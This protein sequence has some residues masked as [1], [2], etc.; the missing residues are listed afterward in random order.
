MWTDLFLTAVG[1]LTV[2]LSVL[3]AATILIGRP[4]APRADRFLA[5]FLLVSAV[6][7]AGW[8]APLMPAATSQWLVFRL[9][10]AY[11][12]MP[13]LLAYVATLGAAKS[14][15]RFH[16]WAGSVLV[17]ASIF[18]LTPRALGMAGTG[19]LPQLVSS[20]ADLQWNDVA[21]HLQ[22][23]VY[24]VLI[25]LAVFS[26]TSR[27]TDPETRRWLKVLLVVS[28]SAHTLV[29]AKS[30]AWM[31]GA[32]QLFAVLNV[33][34]GVSAASVL[35]TLLLLVLLKGG[36]AATT[37]TA[38]QPRPVGAADLAAMARIHDVMVRTLP[39]LDPQL[40]LRGLARR[41][42][43]TSRE[44][45]RLINDC[46]GIHFFDFVN[47]YRTQTAAAY[48][49]DP[50]RAERSVLEIAYEVGFNSKS[51]FNT[52]FR[53]HRGVTPSSVRQARAIA[54]DDHPASDFA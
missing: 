20:G 9:P 12:Q 10:V 11:L 3:L 39:Y 25:A 8:T 4:G 46:E 18:S 23:Y 41:V 32:T 50:V 30:A 2:S 5:A 17:L 31:A 21:L 42:G 6:D 36:R 44:V 22:F 26:R 15:A 13:C 19:L 38:R 51:S 7:L 29:L 24:A 16:L 45:S 40:N 14:K 27:I 49:V 1:V 34:V 28:I 35:V 52:A 37:T 54:D 53:K 47:R 48:L 43:L 33:A